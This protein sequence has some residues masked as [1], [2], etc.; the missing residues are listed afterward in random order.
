MLWCSFASVC[1]FIS[2]F[3]HFYTL[4]SLRYTAP[5]II[6]PVVRSLSYTLCLPSLTLLV[7]HTLWA[8]WPC[9]GSFIHINEPGGLFAL[10]RACCMSLCSH[11]DT[12]QMNTRSC[13]CSCLCAGGEKVSSRGQWQLGWAWLSVGEV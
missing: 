8:L 4:Q 10:P 11:H 2:P 1:L 12:Y 3:K 5:L 7:I 13:Q 6:C 9:P